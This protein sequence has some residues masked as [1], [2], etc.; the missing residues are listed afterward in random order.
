MHPAR[1][2]CD[3]M[4]WLLLSYLQTPDG[5]PGFWHEQHSALKFWFLLEHWVLTHVAG[6]V[7]PGGAQKNVF[8]GHLHVQSGCLV[9][10]P[11]HG[12]T[13]VWVPSW[14]VH[15]VVPVGHEQLPTPSTHLNSVPDGQLVLKHRSPHRTKFR[16]RSHS[17][18][19]AP[20][21]P[22]NSQMR[23]ALVPLESVAQQLPSEPAGRQASPS[24]RHVDA[25]L[26]FFLDL[27]FL[28]FF[29]A[30]TS[31]DPKADPV[32]AA[33]APTANPRN[34]PR[35]V[36]RVVQTFLSRS[37]NFSPSIVFFPCTSDGWTESVSVKSGGTQMV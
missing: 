2:G 25:A 7:D 19:C 34:A 6:D 24:S 27:A 15:G 10:P 28:P 36:S 17:H 1:A 13:H 31:S 9:V 30:A 11:V 33:T 23:P 3:A 8:A 4:R 12:V 32:T 20:V 18:R 37:S 5:C 14:R 29:P 22:T 35:R 26:D 16:V 21:S